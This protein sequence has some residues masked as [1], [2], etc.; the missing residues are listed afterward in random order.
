MIEGVAQATAAGLNPNL[1]KA[2]DQLTPDLGRAMTA[3]TLEA[4]RDAIGAAFGVLPGLMNRSTTGPMVREAQ[5][6]LAGWILQPLAELLAEEASAKLGATVTIDVGRPLQAFDA[7]GRA[8]AFAALIDAIGNAK[9]LGLT[10]AE[11]A[12][13]LSAVNWGGGD[14]NA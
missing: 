14:A 9:A 10:P 6:H 4:A 1:G 5:R 8:R 13:A 3:E 11:V 2:P 12:G 7:G